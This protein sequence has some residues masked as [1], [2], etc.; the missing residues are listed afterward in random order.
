MNGTDNLQFIHTSVPSFM[1]DSYILGDGVDH[2]IWNITNVSVDVQFK[3]EQ[4]NPV[5]LNSNYNS[6]WAGHVRASIEDTEVSLFH[7]TE[8]IKWTF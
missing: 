1:A 2:N 5:Y 3:F 6:K 7:D 4:T 8:C